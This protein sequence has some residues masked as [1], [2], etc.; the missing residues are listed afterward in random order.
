VTVVAKDQNGLKA[1]YAYLS[2]MGSAGGGNTTGGRIIRCTLIKN[3]VNNNLDFNNCTALVTGLTGLRGLEIVSIESKNYLYYTN[4]KLNTNALF[5]REILQ[6]GV[7]GS[8]VTQPAVFPSDT[9]NSSY[10]NDQMYVLRI[11]GAYFKYDK[12]SYTVTKGNSFTMKINFAGT[13]TIGSSRVFFGKSNIPPSITFNGQSVGNFFAD[14]AVE[15]GFDTKTVTV[16]VPSSAS[17]GSYT[18]SGITSNGVLVPSITIKV[19]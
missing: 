18:L 11:P 9:G 12:N 10:V 13:G 17:V 3:S 4:N 1:R 8:E 6:G 16:S 15:S 19:Q 7:L 2:D 5:S 14:F